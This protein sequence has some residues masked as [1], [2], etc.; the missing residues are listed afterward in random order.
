MRILV[1]G[2]AGFIGASVAAA[3]LERGDQVIGIDNLSDY[4]DTQLKKDRLAPLLQHANFTNII[5]DIEKPGTVGDIFRRYQPQRVVHLAAQPGVRYSLENPDIYVQTNIVGFLNILEGC[6]NTEVEHLVYASTSSVYGANTLMPYSVRQS[7]N[8]PLSLYAA[9]KK[10]NEVMAHCYSHLFRIPMSGLRFF[11]VYGPWTRPDMAL[12]TFTRKILA[13]EPIDVFNYGHHRRDFTYIDDIVEGIVR[14]LD[15]VAKADPG[16]QSDAP[17]PS[18]S[19]APWRLY[20]IGSN[21][22]VELNRYIEVLEDCLG[23]RATKNFLPMQPG[24]VAET[25]ADVTSLIEGVGYQPQTAIETGVAN[26]VEWY[27]DYYRP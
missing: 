27:R 21:R 25:Y 20:N 12:M 19:S 8:H 18:T 15:H 13:G 4:Y 22:P 23:V 17:D 14:T 6:R 24:D 5:D 7:V 26:F 3:L 10:S 11:T 9:T 16:W 1:T 2:S